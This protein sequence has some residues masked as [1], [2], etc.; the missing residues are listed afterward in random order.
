MKRTSFKLV[1]LVLTVALMG[2][3]LVSCGT[4]RYSRL[5]ISFEIPRNFEE[6]ANPDALM[7]FGS[8]EAFI[9]F[10]KYTAADLALAGLSELDVQGFTE[11]FLEKSELSE[12]VEPTYNATGD[13]AEF[14]YIVEDPEV[15][16]TYYYYYAVILEGADCIWAVQMACY[17][18]LA[19]EYE[20]K[21]EK[22]ASSLAVRESN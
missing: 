20:P 13:R 22:W 10:N 6:R 1:T 5:G 2:A 12:T 3:L 17:A 11:N 4:S 7:A 9:V 18:P 16:E 15:P 8:D 19:A 14:D 21:F